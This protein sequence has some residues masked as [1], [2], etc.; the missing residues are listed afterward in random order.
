MTI[1][2]VIFDI[3]GVLLTNGWDREQRAKTWAAF[4]LNPG[5]IE[6][7]HKQYRDALDDGGINLSDYLDRTIF[8][9][10][11]SF[12]KEEF[13]TAM[14]AVS[15]PFPEMLAL[16]RR[17][18]AAEKWFVCSLNNECRELHRHRV[19]TYKLKEIFSVS[20]CSAYMRKSKPNPEIYENALGM[21]GVQPSETV[22]IDDR[23][24]NL[25]PAAALGM[26]IIHHTLAAD[27]EQRLKA[28]LAWSD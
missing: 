4:G 8:D 10:A 2:T 24:K 15:Q 20:F 9:A 18:K 23:E 19:A 11:R 16:A 1:T 3:G 26:N 14:K 17:V 6:E 7:K 28:L 5:E 27:T 25:P 22:L 21:L 13:I 12:S